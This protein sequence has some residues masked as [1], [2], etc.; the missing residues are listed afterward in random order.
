[1]NRHKKYELKRRNLARLPGT[2][3]KEHKAEIMNAFYAELET[4]NH[5]LTKADMI[6]WAAAF[7]LR[8]KEAFIQFLEERRG[9]RNKAE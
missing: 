1:M 3:V 7:A 9:E 2:R 5:E 6:V 8:E 4:T